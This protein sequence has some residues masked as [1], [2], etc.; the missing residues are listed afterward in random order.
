MSQR[1][2]QRLEAEREELLSKLAENDADL[3]EEDGRPASADEPVILADFLREDLD[4]MPWLIQGL[5][6]E[7]SVA[8]V[9][10]T[11]GVG[12]TTLLAQ[13]SLCLAAG[14]HV[15]A[16]EA[17]IERPAPVLY[18]AAEGA[19]V[20]FRDRVETARR[21]LSI[22]ASAARWFI[23]PRDLTD[24]RIGSR[25][26]SRLLDRSACRLAVLDTLGY[27]WRGDR[28]SDTD[29][30]ERVMQPLRSH[31][32]QTGTAFLL[33]HHLGKS[34]DWKGR[35]TSA[36]HDDSDLFIQMEPGEDAVPGAPD[37]PVRVWVRKN[38]Y[39]PSGYFFDVTY[40]TQLA[41]FEKGR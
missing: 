19:R 12:K 40:R 30:K 28:N 21:S 2:R 35:G 33:V 20:A 23:Q 13:L 25:G 22:P 11:G 17:R 36:M 26:L 9:V 8:M 14:V 37:Q 32:A 34:D 6:A 38:K 39:G 7:G 1:R 41:I 29:W 10:A 5:L 15:P 16:I 4:E 3:R 18:V 24:Y 31:V 27:F